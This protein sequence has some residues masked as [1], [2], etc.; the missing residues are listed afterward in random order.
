V[1]EAAFVATTVSVDEF[2]DVILAGLAEIVTVGDGLGV[3]VTVAVAV[4]V[5]P[6]PVA[7]AVYVVVAVGLTV[8]SPLVLGCPL[9]VPVKV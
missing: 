5:P 1:T 4:V 2:P 8:C 7:V 6:G 9:V 3:T